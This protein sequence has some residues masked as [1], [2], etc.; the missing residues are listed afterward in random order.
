MKGLHPDQAYQVRL[1]PEKKEIHR[2]TGAQLME[3][4]FRVEIPE[5]YDGRIYEIALVE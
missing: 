1:A 5:L 3:K 4:G 2:A